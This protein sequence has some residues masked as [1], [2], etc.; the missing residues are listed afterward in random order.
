MNQIYPLYHS[1]QPSSLTISIYGKVSKTEVLQ[2]NCAFIRVPFAPYVLSL[3]LLI[4][5]GPSQRLQPAQGHFCSSNASSPAPHLCCPSSLQSRRHS[6]EGSTGEGAT[7]GP[8]PP[9]VAQNKVK[10]SMQM[11]NN[12]L[13]SALIPSR[14]WGGVKTAGRRSILR[15][16]DY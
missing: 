6:L 7:C 15:D 9:I 11:E 12:P 5:R 3:H 4:P 1:V 2:H 8:P 16:K 10:G 14:G 13:G